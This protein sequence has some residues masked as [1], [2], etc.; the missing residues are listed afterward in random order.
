MNLSLVSSIYNSL[1]AKIKKKII[2]RK[3]DNYN[4]AEY[5]REQGARIG[6]NCCIMPRSLGSE[7]YLV[8]I[9]NHVCINY[10]VHLHTHDG[11]TW[12]FRDE[13]PDIRVFGPIVIEDN[14]LIGEGTKILPNVTIGKNSI[15]GAGSVVISDVPP[16]SIVMGVPARRFGSLSKYKEKCIDRWKDQ[17]PSDFHFDSSMNWE[18]SKNVKIIRKQLKEH[19][20]KVFKEKL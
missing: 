7:P 11:G 16:N 17:K 18:R 19:L 3:Y 8:K 12:V 4:I 10:D 6:D 1:I 20:L 14:C 15:V 13:M 5:F 9:G 2:L